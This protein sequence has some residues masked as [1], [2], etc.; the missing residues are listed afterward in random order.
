MKKLILILFFLNSTFSFSQTIRAYGTFGVYRSINFEGNG[1]ANFGGGLELKFFKHVRPEIEATYYI[2]TLPDVE[3]FD[4]V[5]SV[6]RDFL[7]RTVS[8]VNYSLAPKIMFDVGQDD[9]VDRYYL[10]IIPKFN[11]TSVTARGDFFEL[12]NNK[13]NYL[14]SAEDKFSEKRKSFGIAIGLIMQF[15]EKSYDALAFNLF[16]NNI[17]IGNAINQLKFKNN[18]INTST[19]FGLG[20]SYYIGFTKIKNKKS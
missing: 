11:F 2:G 19:A 14:V 4:Y 16:Y 1:F 13:T 10:Q 8:A 5:N 9:R 12:N 3:N 20:L 15:W 6:P 17:D 7:V 18:S